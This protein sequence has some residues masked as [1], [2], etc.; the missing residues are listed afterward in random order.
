MDIDNGVGGARGRGGKGNKG[1]DLGGGGEEGRIENIC[2]SVDNRINYLKK[3][4]SGGC[5]FTSP[6]KG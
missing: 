2:N 6:L 3:A 4:A 5:F 1:Q